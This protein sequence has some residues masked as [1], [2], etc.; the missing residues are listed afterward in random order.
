MLSI[1]KIFFLILA[2][3]PTYG[4][5]GR[6]GSVEKK[7]SINFTKSNKKFLLEFTLQW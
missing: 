4:I 5:N 3:S 7:L 1:A 2:L 6:F